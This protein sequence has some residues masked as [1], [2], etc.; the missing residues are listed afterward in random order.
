MK[1]HKNRSFGIIVALIFLINPNI[2]MIDI[3]PDFIAYFLL[4]SI[5]SKS[6]LIVPYFDEAKRA[7]KNL[8]IVTL[9]RIPCMFIVFTNMHT[10]RDIVPL[11][12]LI[13]AVIE[14]VLLFSAIT[15][16]LDGLFYLGQRSDAD[17]LLSGSR[18]F[19]YRLNSDGVRTFTLFV[20]F[21]K[22]AFNVLPE[23]C[24]LSTYNSRLLRIL[25]TAYPIL[26]VTSIMIVWFLGVVWFV[27][28]IQYITKVNRT[29]N[30]HEAIVSMAG[31][32]RLAVIEIKERTRSITNYLTLLAI[33]S[34]FSFDIAFDNTNGINILP[35]FI[36]VLVY[37]ISAGGLRYSLGLKIGLTVT[38][39][40]YTV[41]SLLNHYCTILF[42]DNYEMLDLL[43]RDAA[44]LAYLPIKILSVFELLLFIAF[45]VL[46][47][48]GFVKFI[49]NH[50]GISKD[51]EVYSRVDAVY[52][53]KMIFKSFILFT[54]GM[55]INFGKCLSVFLKAN[56]TVI[57]THSGM[58]VTSAAPWLDF[59]L[60]IMSVV[61]VGYSF[62]FL[63]TVKSDVKFKYDVE[64]KETR[65]GVFE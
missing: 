42:K 44:I 3:L 8:G 31:E 47:L 17:A 33:A 37:L 11:F 60:I 29:C 28:A 19:G 10:G 36:F 57:H 65:K 35:R 39:V 32:E 4:Y 30:L 9:V 1:D 63:S 61:L 46:M 25:S 41:V 52:H 23:F 50:T 38:S 58:I 13:F 48:I 40:F 15:N 5:I 53:R 22:C 14:G 2:N 62:Y 12:T 27:S 20:F 45:S 43:E 6:A 51:S 49:K 24:L 26:L 59:L 21:A 18:I 56:V 64:E 54:L 34:L 7:F 55:L 16:S